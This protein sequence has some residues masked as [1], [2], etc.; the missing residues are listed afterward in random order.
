MCLDG[1]WAGGFLTIGC[2]SVC[3]RAQAP[4]GACTRL[5]T[6][7]SS[8]MFLD[9]LPLGLSN[10]LKNALLVSF[11]E[12]TGLTASSRSFLSRQRELQMEGVGFSN[13]YVYSYLSPLVSM[14]LLPLPVSLE[15]LD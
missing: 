11:Q 4:T 9:L 6:M 5:L 1:R 13:Q 3:A 12:D 14:V 2:V 10:S 15:P 8:S 7:G